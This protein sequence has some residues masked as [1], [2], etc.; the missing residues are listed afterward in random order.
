MSLLACEGLTVEI[1][2][3]RIA[4][5]LDLAVGAGTSWAVLGANGAGKTTLLHTLAGL[6]PPT[7]GRVLLDGRPLRGL[8]RREIARRLGVLLQDSEDPFPATVLE[9]ALIG[10][11]PHI[12]PWRW[13]SPDDHARARA[14]L[15]EVGLSEL[16]TRA[17][18]TLSGGERRRLALATLL[19]QDPAVQL[20]DE[21]S[22]HLDLHHQIALLG[23]LRERV[24][25]AGGA[26]VMALHDVNLAARFCDHA[27]LL[28]TDGSVAHGPATEL[29]QP[30][31][32]SRL[33]HHPIR[34]LE[35]DGHRFFVPA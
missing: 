10:R 32:L 23:H 3:Q 35:A 18:D 17:V 4:E 24:T 29:L 19:A 26:L 28:F 34:E 13:E 15:D 21:P 25:G 30:E 31:R 5:G 20:L 2:G 8:R 1:G 12:G 11:H 14:A 22:N 16:A 9:T 7:A 33:Y 6:R 27:V